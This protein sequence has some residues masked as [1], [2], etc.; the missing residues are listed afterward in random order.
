M[1]GIAQ[2]DYEPGAGG[3]LAGI[4]IL[5]LSR[6]VAGNL[7]TQILGDYGAEVVKVEPPDG[8]TLR[9]WKTKGVATHWKIYARNKKSLCL[10]L[11][12]PRAIDL[13]RRLVPTAAILVES[14][15]P[16]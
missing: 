13:V 1:T 4:R 10:S 16:A 7:L 9:A 3:P 11:R 15:R 2:R 5:D 14:F 12:D 8:D 6:L